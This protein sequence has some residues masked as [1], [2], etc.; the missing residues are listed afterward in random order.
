MLATEWKND[1]KSWIFTLRPNVKF[2]DGTVMTAQDAAYSINRLMGLTADPQPSAT[3]TSLAPYIEKAEATGDLQVTIFTK[4]VDGLLPLRLA[5]VN[6]CIVPE[7]Y[8]T[9]TKFE[10]LQTKPIGAGPFKLVSFAAGDR[11]V[12]EAHA[13]YWGGRPNIDQLVIRP[14]PETATRIAAFQAGELDL[15]TTVPPDSIDSLKS[16]STRVDV[17]SVFNWMLIYFNTNK[18]PTSNVDFRRALSLSIDRK[19]IAESLWGGRVRVM[20]DYFL[21]GEFGYDEARPQFAF[22]LD[23]AKKALDAAKYSGEAL[24]FTPPAQYYTNGRLV[25]DAINEFWTNAGI[26]VQYEPLDNQKWFER[27]LAGNNIATL[28]S[29]GTSGDPGTGVGSVWAPGLWIAKYF[30]PDEANQKLLTEAASS[31]DVDLRRK[32]YRTFADYLDAQVPIAPLYQSVEFYGVKN[33]VKWTPS[34][35]FQL[36][37]RPNNFTR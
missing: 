5:A 11:S 32:N 6:T 14:I 8:Y 37:L 22:D 17:S 7:A 1:G 21:P 20:N 24:E 4:I 3:R 34:A 33:D 26:K 27:S 12:L 28:Q 9:A 18:G 2:H 10:A 16:A 25:T 36:D 13:D 31:T 29:F 30:Q 35:T 19:A 15:V 23:A